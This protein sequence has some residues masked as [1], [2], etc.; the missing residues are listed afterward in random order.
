MAK[1]KLTSLAEEYDTDFDELKNLCAFNLDE[2]M[3]TGVG[4]NT[5]ID[6]RGQ[7]I[8]DDLVPMPVIYRGPVISECPNPNYLF[9]RHRDRMCKVVV[10]IPRRMRGK[11]LD[12]VIY[13]E[14]SRK[15]ETL[16][17][18]WVKR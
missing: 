9:V 16:K 3:M 8:L 15:G 10:Q 6:E 11:L 14:E 1:K 13:F 17:Y 4:R 2:E 7:A 5:W 12:K 18:K